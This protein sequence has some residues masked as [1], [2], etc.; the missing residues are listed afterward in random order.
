M[1]EKRIDLDASSTVLVFGSNLKGAH[2]RGA[3]HFARQVFGARY[4]CGIGLTGRSYAI[5][6]KDASIQTLPL[7]II[8]RY[9]QDFIRFAYQN[10][11]LDLIVTQVGCGLAG[12]QASQVAP[13]F[14][15]VP[16]NCIL[17]SEWLPHIGRTHQD[18]TFVADNLSL[19]SELIGNFKSAAGAIPASDP[20]ATRKPLFKRN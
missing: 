20:S 1:M 5:P 6:T 18:I 12:Y 4:G 7:D 2:G 8:D 19:Y 3:A 10:P 16:E 14:K 15:D 9:I 17:P 11:E 13:L